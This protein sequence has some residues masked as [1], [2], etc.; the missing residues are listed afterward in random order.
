MRLVLGF[1]D[2]MV[3]LIA[4]EARRHSE[5]CIQYS[6]LIE[7]RFNELLERCDKAGK[8]FSS[9]RLMSV[10]IPQKLSKKPLC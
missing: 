8:R 10:G 7:A 4:T 3:D 9:L 5:T 2:E 6:V 1:D